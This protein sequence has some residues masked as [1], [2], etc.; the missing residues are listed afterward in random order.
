MKDD[1]SGN[2]DP[3]AIK[4]YVSD[5]KKKYDIEGGE[6]E[7]HSLTGKTFKVSRGNYCWV[8]DETGEADQLTADIN[9]HKDVKRPPVFSQ[10]ATG[11]YSK[12]L[13]IGDT[14]V[15]ADL[16]KQHVI[17]FKDGKKKWESDCVSGCIAY[18][19]D[20]PAGV[21]SILGKGRGITLTSGGKKNSPG[22]YESYVSYWMPFIGNNYGLHD[23]S[24]RSE[25]GGDIYKYSGSHGCINLPPSKA[26]ELYEVVSVGDPVI[27]HYN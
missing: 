1:L 27:V 17:F 5:L 26:G 6:V 18:G 7:F 12:K 19:H 11:E 21:Y 24:W 14:Y 22:Y 8:I 3:A 9:S 20:T 23:A 4:K 13:N 2:A 16:G 25:F 10:T 15:D